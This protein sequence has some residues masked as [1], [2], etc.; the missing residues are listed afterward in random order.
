MPYPLFGDGEYVVSRKLSD[1]P[2]PDTR[3]TARWH[4]CKNRAC[5]FSEIAVCLGMFQIR[6]HKRK[7][8]EQKCRIS[9]C[10]YN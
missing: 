10:L 6:N 2:R 5:D 4:I 3:Q 7:G 8:T 1:I 9:R